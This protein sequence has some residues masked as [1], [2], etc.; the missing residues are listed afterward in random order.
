MRPVA[1]RPVLHHQLEAF[2]SEG[3]DDIVVV[4]A[5]DA[6][7]LDAPGAHVI[8]GAVP[9]DAGPV[10]MLFAAET[11]LVGDV[12][13]C[14]GDIVF[15]PQMVRVLREMPY[16]VSLVIDRGFRRRSR[17]LGDPRLCRLTRSGAVAEFGRRVHSDVAYGRYVGLGRFDAA[18]VARL[19]SHYLQA[20]AR[21]VEYSFGGAPSMRLADVTDLFD[22]SIRAGQSVHVVAVE[23]G[24]H[25]IPAGSDSVE[26]RDAAGW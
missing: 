12:L 15:H 4:C 19:W 9:A 26:T 5:G 6:T 7:G 23:G 17:G 18:P 11:E 25:A 20:V 16:G 13:V 8:A 3:I 2:Q 21:G 24:W 1:G 22:I 10:T 14:D